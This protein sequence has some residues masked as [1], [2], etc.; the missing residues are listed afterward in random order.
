[1]RRWLWAAL[2]LGLPASGQPLNGDLA[3]Q[4]EPG[5]LCRAAIVAAERTHGT[6]TGLLAAIGR[7]ESGRRDPLTGAVHPWPWTINAEGRGALLD[8]REA[9]IARV[10]EEQGRGVRSIDV[11]CMQVNLMFHPQAFASL[12]EAFDPIR[13]ADYAGRLLRTLFQQT[14][15]WEAAAG[16]Y[17]SATPELAARYLSRLAEAIAEEGRMAAGAA[18]STPLAA[19]TARV[20][21]AL[22]AMP[23]PPPLPASAYAV[24]R[25]PE[26]PL[27]ASPPNALP[28]SPWV[29][30]IVLPE[31]AQP[32]RRTQ[33]SVGS[34][35]TTAAAGLPAARA[36]PAP[37]AGGI[38][39]SQPIMPVVTAAGLPGAA[40]APT[41]GG[42]GLDAYRAQPV[43]V[44]SG[45]RRM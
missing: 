32:T 41:S 19:A 34:A 20:A 18:A 5:R 2:A 15:S 35:A 39:L 8:S 29:A 3:V 31:Q 11:G 6:P 21:A 22:A 37:S 45:T 10:R 9:A 25:E 36:V 13:N 38:P 1:M 4:A 7:V 43:R 14:G 42:R 24:T 30:R 16:R 44:L 27:G 33:P 12:E 26:R 23:P 28:T 40:A 17:H